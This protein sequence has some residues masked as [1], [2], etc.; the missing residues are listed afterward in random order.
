M[1]LAEVKRAVQMKHSDTQ[2]TEDQIL[3]VLQ[4]PELEATQVRD[5][6]A[7]AKIGDHDEFRMMMFQMLGEV[8]R[9]TITEICEE[10]ERRHGKPCTLGAFKIRQL[11]R[12]IAEKVD[13]GETWIVKR[14]LIR[15]SN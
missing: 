1:T 10:Y 2:I 13:H 7:L 6:W 8:D 3:R 5:L 11:L 12:E 15:D 9:I 14:A 4:D